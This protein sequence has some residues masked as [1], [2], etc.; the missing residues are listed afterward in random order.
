MVS[1]R[2]SSVNIANALSLFRDGGKQEKRTSLLPVA[3]DGLEFE[4]VVYPEFGVLPPVARLLV[5]AE[6]R[7]NVPWRIIDVDRACAQ[8]GGHR[9]GVLDISRGDI[10]REA[11]NRVIGDPDGLV[12]VAIAHNRENRAERLLAL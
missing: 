10:G 8:P 7:V 4:I 5:S 3:H 6:G 12:L 11:V 9:A 2:L 1:A